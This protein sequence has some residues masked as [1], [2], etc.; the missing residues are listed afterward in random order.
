M[1]MGRA[2]ER[3]EILIYDL[4]FVLRRWIK[5]NGGKVSIPYRLDY[6]NAR[7]WLPAN[8][9]SYCAL[10]LTKDKVYDNSSE[11]RL[12]R[13]TALLNS[14]KHDVEYTLEWINKH[15]GK[16]WLEIKESSRFLNPPAD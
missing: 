10:P 11:K 2:A 13:A 1:G 3:I 4:G 7:V 6:V 9:A 8:A 5:N 15:E 14:G 16:I 12:C